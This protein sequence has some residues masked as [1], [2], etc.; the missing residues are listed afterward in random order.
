MRFCN[1]FH[2]IFIVVFFTSHVYSCFNEKK[3]FVEISGDNKGDIERYI[4]NTCSNVDI[5]IVESF[6]TCLIQIKEQFKDKAVCIDGFKDIV[7]KTGI[8]F[9]CT[10]YAL[11]DG[12][13]AYLSDKKDVLISKYCREN[14][15]NLSSYCSIERNEVNNGNNFPFLY[16][17]CKKDDS[18]LVADMNTEG[19][20][21]IEV[22]T[23]KKANE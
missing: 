7:N 18:S 3:N 20:V 17:I 2:K 19:E 10:L 21:C 22:H 5:T 12:K 8:K 16:M 9:P 14:D 13:V 23:I 4:K 1:L 15:C 11:Y 6:V